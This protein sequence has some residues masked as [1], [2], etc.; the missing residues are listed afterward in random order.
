MQQQIS[1][2]ELAMPLHEVTFAILDIETTGGS[3]DLNAIT[4]IG[5]VK[6]KGG[7]ILG[8]FQTLVNP[9]VAI[10]INI[11]SINHTSSIQ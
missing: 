11:D 7:E 6:V 4:E 5:I 8:E 2:D 3:P 10:P 1:F 9:G